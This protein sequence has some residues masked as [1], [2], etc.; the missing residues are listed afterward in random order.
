MEV[1]PAFAQ[2]DLRERGWQKFAGTVIG[3]KAP[4]DSG[5][6]R[7]NETERMMAILGIILGRQIKL[8]K[9]NRLT[10]TEGRRS[11]FMNLNA[12]TNS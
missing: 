4:H 6:T 11:P 2:E 3:T 7:S 12:R 8:R 5:E 10:K 1:T 9:P